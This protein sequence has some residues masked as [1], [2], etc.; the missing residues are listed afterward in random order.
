MPFYDFGARGTATNWAT[1]PRR[2]HR[3]DAHRPLPRT[4][5]GRH[6]GER[7][8]QVRRLPARNRTSSLW[9]PS[10]A[11]SPRGGSR[12]RRGDRP[13]DDGWPSRHARS[14]PGRAPQPATTAEALA[15]L[16]PAFA[17]GGTVTAGN[18]SGINDG[19]AAV[20]VASASRSHV[21]AGPHRPRLLEAVD[22]GRDRA[23][24]MGYAPVFALQ[25]PLR[26][27][28]TLTERHRHRGAQRGLRRSGRRRHP[29][30]RARPGAQ[31]TPTAAPSRWA[32]RWAPP[33]PSSP[34]GSPSTCA[35]PT[36]ELGVVTMCIGGGQALAA[37]FRRAA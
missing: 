19:A 22:H 29:R 31:S 16:R 37:L 1:G 9:S 33:A 15:A 6:R 13:G 11:A 10:N 25:Q 4:P 30:R 26:A 21:T 20:I 7:R 3:D 18:A 5:H 14:W 8:R 32:T 28:R 24:L 2:R 17:D 23:R 27:D 36:T 12:L 35:A 34:C